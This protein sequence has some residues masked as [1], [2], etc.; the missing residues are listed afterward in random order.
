MKKIVFIVALLVLFINFGEASFAAE[1]FDNI[2]NE[3]VET[4]FE[5]L[6]V[7]DDTLYVSFD[8]TYI[9]NLDYYIDYTVSKYCETDEYYF[10]LA[11]VDRYDYLIKLNKKTKELDSLE[12]DIIVNDMLVS[13]GVLYLVGNDSS[14]GCIYKYSMKLEFISK[15]LYG[16]EGWESFNQIEII[17]NKVY[18]VGIKDAISKYSP[19]INC[20]NSGET[21]SFLVRL[22]LGLVI[23]DTF[24]FNEN[25]AFEK[26]VDFKISNNYLLCINKDASDNN[27]QYKLSYDFELIERFNLNRYYNIE[28]IQLITYTYNNSY[29]YLYTSY[30]CAYFS[31]FLGDVIYNAY[32]KQLDKLCYI[33]FVDNKLQ[34]G[35]FLKEEFIKTTVDEYH[36]VFK[37]EKQISFPA[38]NYE[39]T[40]HFLV[41]SYFENLIFEYSVE[42]D[43]DYLKSGTYDATYISKKT[44][45]SFIEI[46]TPIKVLPYINV[47]D[48]G[49]YN[50]GYKLTF[51]D[52]LYV[53]GE[54]IYRGEEL[55]KEGEYKLHHEVNNEVKEYVIYIKAN[56]NKDLSVNHS[57]SNYVI[58]YGGSFTYDLTLSSEKIVKQ[59][60]VNDIAFPFTQDK[61]LIKIYFNSLKRVGISQYHIDKIIFEDE[62]E[63]VIDDSFCVNILKE[64]PKV[65]VDVTK[66]EIVSTL[67][68]YYNSLLDVE[69]NY[70]KD[71]KLVNIQKTYLSDL[72]IINDNSFDELKIFVLYEQ[73]TQDIYKKEVLSCKTSDNSYNSLFQKITKED[74]LFDI[75]FDKD[76]NKVVSFSICNIL[77]DEIINSIL[78]GDIE[79]SAMY[80]TQTSN[81]ILYTSLM[82]SGV[83]L[84]AITI[85]QVI[86]KK[87]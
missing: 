79:V 45:G 46:T 62:T 3:V 7:I 34:M 4:D 77:D 22:N 69:I 83:V 38:Q 11:E 28:T 20:G 52:K 33:K 29:I 48:G 78:I 51:T 6:D 74:V 55:T 31:V 68:D 76:E 84:L 9:K 32:I 43:I 36:V 17:N 2:Q 27:Y 30:D 35:S 23:E 73:G 63:Y 59:I 87:K 54:E 57:F 53:N 24:Y 65:S 18:I 72:K 21:K 25:T 41:E 82:V 60:V 13:Q 5:L 50:V 40:A 47:I 80:I 8:K 42:N 67:N 19:F 10:F 71:Q 44:D 37:Q 86:K 14:D 75:V 39:D 26:I 66:D 16:G 1:H 64:F 70:Y 12:L 61:N 81:T 49:I 85:K 15:H 56:Y 58:P